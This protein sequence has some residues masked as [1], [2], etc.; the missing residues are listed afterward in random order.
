MQVHLA[1]ICEGSEKDEMK[2]TTIIT[3]DT[4]TLELTPSDGNDKLVLEII[5]GSQ[6]AKVSVNGAIKIVVPRPKRPMRFEPTDG[7]QQEE[8]QK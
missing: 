5:R 6:D 1:S 7:A 8:E 2:T 3:D 4:I